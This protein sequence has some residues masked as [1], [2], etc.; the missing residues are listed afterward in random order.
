MINWH[1]GGILPTATD[2]P[3]TPICQYPDC[4]S[5]ILSILFGGMFRAHPSDSGSAVTR[6]PD[7]ITFETAQHLNYRCPVCG[8]IVDATSAEEILLHHEHVT[9]PRDFLLEKSKVA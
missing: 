7:A 5:L 1:Q 2:S 3:D 6:L 4:G 8:K 9:H